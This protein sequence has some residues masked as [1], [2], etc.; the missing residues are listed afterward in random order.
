[1]G[2]WFGALEDVG[3][4]GG[5]WKGRRVFL[6]GHTGFKGSWLALLLHDAGARV[7]GYA[8]DPP[9]DPSLFAVARVASLLAGHTIAD[10]RDAD[11]LGAAMHSASPDIVFHLAAQSLV[12]ESY[13]QPVE[14]YAVNVL[15]SVNLLEAVRGCAS[16][17]AVVNVTSDKCYE[18]A[19]TGR[20]H[21]ESDPLGGHD[22]YSS[23]KACAE[24]VTSAYRDSFLA[25]RGVAVA[26]ARAGNVIGG[27]DW[28]RDRL[29]PDFLRALDAGH[30]ASIRHPEA[31][32][33][34]QHVLEPV[35]AY[36]LLAQALVEDGA[37][38]AGAWNFG[39]DEADACTVGWLLDRLTARRPQARWERDAGKHP[40]EAP[41]LMLSSAKARGELG[42]QPR[43]NVAEAVDRT[44]EWHD[45]WR[46]GKDMRA[47]CIEQIEAFRQP[48]NA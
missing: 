8:I 33:P 10:I 44:L 7:F 3:M 25:T 17:R 12:R 29:V 41:T 45:A 24:L 1:V 9:T 23:S 6:T 5:F 47:V 2:E 38:R 43:W 40:R 18:N 32:R 36:L 30:A 15:G 48:V 37:T 46:G 28:A 21:E 11:A 4:S 39:P 34:W 16:V 42:W 22:P 14:T 27:G 13:R 26:T 19:G 20:A 35:S 31:I